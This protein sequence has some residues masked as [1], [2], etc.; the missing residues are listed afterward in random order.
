[1]LLARIECEYATRPQ[2][3]VYQCDSVAGP[4]R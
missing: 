1:M 2:F 4:P 3:P